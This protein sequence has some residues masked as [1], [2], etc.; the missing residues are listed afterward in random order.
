MPTKYIFLTSVIKGFDKIVQ[1]ENRFQIYE[2]HNHPKFTFK[3]II[4]DDGLVYFTGTYINIGTEFKEINT[5]FLS[6]KDIDVVWMSDG[7]RCWYKGF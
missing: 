5:I 6:V 7:K 2:H 3:K 1:I 4:L